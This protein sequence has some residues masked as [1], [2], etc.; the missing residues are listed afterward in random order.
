[1]DSTDEN[2][3][4]PERSRAES[5]EQVLSVIFSRREDI[6]ELLISHGRNLN[7]TLPNGS[8]TVICDVKLYVRMCEPS[9]L[10]LV[11]PA[12]RSVIDESYHRGYTSGI[13]KP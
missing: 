3:A 5:E 11:G 2:W 6:D 10:L 8:Y 1:M 7:K 12:N 13:W 4:F 9:I